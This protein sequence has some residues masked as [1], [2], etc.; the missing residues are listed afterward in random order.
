MK[1]NNLSKDKRKTSEQCVLQLKVSLWNLNKL[2]QSYR[3]IR[4]GIAPIPL[5]C[6]SAFPIPAKASMNASWAGAWLRLPV[7]QL[8]VE[9]RLEA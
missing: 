1:E 8:A 3:K 6:S 5:G 4:S 2:A 7:E 9:V